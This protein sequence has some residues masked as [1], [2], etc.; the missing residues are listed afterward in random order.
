MAIKL[1]GGEAATAA[2]VAALMHARKAWMQKDAEAP[3]M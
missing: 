1:L 2:A 3:S